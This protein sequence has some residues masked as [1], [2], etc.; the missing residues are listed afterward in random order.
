MWTP[1]WAA[2]LADRGRIV[3]GGGMLPVRVA[4]IF[5]TCANA[6]QWFTAESQAALQSHTADPPRRD[7]QVVTAEWKSRPGIRPDGRREA[8]R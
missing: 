3:H 5:R 2:P 6:P 8:E 1:H 7:P 4:L